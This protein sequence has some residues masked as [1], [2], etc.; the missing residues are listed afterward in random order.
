MSP[1]SHTITSETLEWKGIILPIA[2]VVVT[3][4]FSPLPKD[5]SPGKRTP[6]TVT[7]TARKK[8][9]PTYVMQT[10]F[11]GGLPEHG[12]AVT[13]TLF[14]R[15]GDDGS[16]QSH[17]LNLVVDEIECDG[18]NLSLRL[19]QR[20]D[21]FTIPI[22]I[23]PC[24][25][26]HTRYWAVRSDRFTK[27]QIGDAG[28]TRSV[29]PSLRWPLYYALR[30]G[31]YS[32]TPPPLPTIQLD[33]PLQGAYTTNTWDNPYYSQDADRDAAILSNAKAIDFFQNPGGWGAA[34][35]ESE[36]VS[37]IGFSGE[38][39]RSRSNKD[40]T[41][42]PS[43]ASFNGVWFM[44]EGIVQVTQAKP[45]NDIGDR[46]YSQGHTFTSF[47]IVR[48]ADAVKDPDNLY[49]VKFC[50]SSRRGLALRWNQA[51]HF[52][53]YS[54]AYPQ[55]W[56]GFSPSSESVVKEFD[57]DGWRGK[58]EIPVVIE[59][60]ADQVII[61]V[62]T[63]HEVKF[64]TP[65]ITG[66]YGST[67]TWVEV[68]IH[69]PSGSAAMGV[70]GVQV[71][72]IPMNEPYRSR[73]MEVAK[74][75]HRFTPKARIFSNPILYTQGVLPSVRAKPAGEVLDDI[76]SSAGLTWWIRPDGVAVVVPLEDLERSSYGSTYAIN[77]SSDVKDIS[78]SK[79]AVDAKSS[80]E[81]EYAAVAMCSFEEARWVLYEGGGYADIGK[82][83]EVMLTADE[84]LD[85]LEPDFT[86]ED[87]ATQGYRWLR[88]GVGSFYGGG[89]E[90]QMHWHNPQGVLQDGPKTSVAMDSEFELTKITPWSV[91]L[92]SKY[93]TPGRLP[94]PGGGRFWQRVNEGALQAV[95]NQEYRP[96]EI[97]V[98]TPTQIDADIHG[99]P[100]IRARGQ[101]KRAKKTGTIAGSVQNAGVLQVGS[102]DWLMGSG[103]AK[104]AGY[105]IAPWVLKPRLQIKSLV[106]R[107]RPEVSIGDTVNIYGT[108]GSEM[109]RTFDGT[110]T[111]IVYSV[112]HSP[113]AGE[114][115]L[116]VMV[117]PQK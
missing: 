2:D 44:T 37:G 61:R 33:L 9:S 35:S 87:M 45:R 1:I 99:L 88:S 12:D 104:T 59:Q 29:N 17:P 108:Y 23:S 50:T 92:T 53:V 109:G 110:L 101:L 56:A 80:L 66:R 78:I 30:A 54:S 27:E 34:S 89:T 39:A 113:S 98:G 91:R 65:S 15:Y 49:Q 81:I 63:I 18:D 22:S 28:E 97:R 94:D 72:G 112:T 115:S 52:W 21:S 32:V 8:A 71:A 106:I 76:C 102:W 26:H 68:W 57:I 36:G 51:G 74:D 55:E 46:T 42:S 62:G 105:A 11:E 79:S 14:K 10:P 114:T 6:L 73:F 43:A 67:P 48:S 83:I 24:P 58:R 5:V 64:N 107:Y 75:Y 60:I 20:I 96:R 41:G 82:P 70:T 77:V 19:I 103:F 84:E 47:M 38:L 3:H 69:N 95:P 7:C 100:I 13:M 31:G 86:V 25:P 116:G 85:W 111:G 4:E 117:K 93:T 90:Y 40:G 16:T